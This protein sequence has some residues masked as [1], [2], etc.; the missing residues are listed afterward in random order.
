MDR[1][2][3]VLEGKPASARALVDFDGT[4]FTYG[5]LQMESA[6]LAQ[7][8]QNHGVRGGDRVVL[9]A[10]NSVLYAAMV[11]AASRLNAWLVLVNARQSAEEIAAIEAHATP[12]C[13]IFTHSA[14][15]PARAHAKRLEA[16]KIGALA[17]G[18]IYA[19]K[20]KETET[21]PVS[22]GSDQVA[23][24]LYTT[25]TTSAPKG[26]MLTH[27][28]LL[29]SAK[30]SARFHGLTPDDRVV[31]VL[32]GTHIYA[33]ASVFLP[34]MIA[35]ATL[36]LFARFDTRAVLSLLR[37]GATRFPA[38]P[39]MMAAIMQHLHEAGENLNAPALISMMTGG[40]PLD[41]GLKARAE[42][43][44]GIPLNNGYGMTET[45]PSIA[46]THNDNP[47]DDVG[48]GAPYEWIEVR[49]WDKNEHGIGE[50]QVRGENV[51]KGY[52]RAPERTA[53]AMTDDGFFRTGDL[54]RF[55]DGGGLHI[56]G[57]LKELI[58]RSGFNV[59][60]PE[61][62]A[63]LSK[64][65]DVF[66]VAVVGRMVPGDEEIL[67]FVKGTDALQEEA[68][69]L[70]L[71]DRLVGYKIPSHIFIVDT[72]PAA[73]TGKIF[74]HKLLDHFADRIS[75]KDTESAAP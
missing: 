43:V 60:P 51:M 62:E 3:Q 9:V 32:P 63:M 35:G 31:G 29:F 19:T 41:P 28:N 16:Q 58:I 50:I 72:Y 45:S 53:E 10:E 61:I 44:F 47:R 42:K 26:V 66:Q 40:A 5:E 15:E 69:K 33:L 71:R 1:L 36:H 55:D 21:E 13:V 46:A 7:I 23:V 70:W 75:Q 56:V 48:V 20:V 64:H 52:Y 17:C 18:P 49:L 8:L 22:A 74:K 25:G 73:A 38:V 2:H 4:A 27:K 59:H 67:A 68:L 39:Q 12:R 11:F 6:A 30:N 54:G 14:S 57:R 65:P 34:A 37:G 24:L